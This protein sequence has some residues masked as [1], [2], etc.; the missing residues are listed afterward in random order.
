VIRAECKS[1]IY[2]EAILVK[3]DLKFMKLYKLMLAIFVLYYT[4]LFSDEV[5]LLYSSSEDLC[6]NLSR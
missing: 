3:E 6:I 2:H 1:S 5:E 4:L